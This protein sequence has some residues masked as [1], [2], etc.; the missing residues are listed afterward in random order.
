MAKGNRQK[1]YNLDSYGHNKQ[2]NINKISQ[3]HYQ[4]KSWTER[5]WHQTLFTFPFLTSIYI[6][7]GR[8]LNEFG[9][10]TVFKK[11]FGCT[12]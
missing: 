8:L 11:Y 1:S 9:Y 5:K 3:H 12:I 6:L 4:N 10:H 2:G 7:V